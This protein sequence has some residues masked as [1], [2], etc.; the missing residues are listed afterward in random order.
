LVHPPRGETARKIAAPDHSEKTDPIMHRVTKESWL[1]RSA[2]R[3]IARRAQR[4]VALGHDT[5][6]PPRRL[7]KMCRLI[8]DRMQD[9]WL[10]A[11]IHAK[12]AVASAGANVGPEGSMYD[13]ELGRKQMRKIGVPLASVAPAMVVYSGVART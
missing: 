13:S 1:T 12:Q 5:K 9:R 11:T 10:P 7:D 2:D 3:S 8:E 6:E 4:A